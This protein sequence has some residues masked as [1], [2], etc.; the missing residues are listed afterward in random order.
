MSEEP[1]IKKWKEDI[2]DISRLDA[3]MKI[4]IFKLIEQDLKKL[5]FELTDKVPLADWVRTG[6]DTFI[7]DRTV[8]L[9]KSKILGKSHINGGIVGDK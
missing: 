1:L 7:F 9:I 3:Q 6:Q 8:E 2:N 4:D 5:F